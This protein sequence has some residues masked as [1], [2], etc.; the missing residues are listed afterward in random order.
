MVAFR[1][2]HLKH[3]NEKEKHKQMLIRKKRTAAAR[4]GRSRVIL[5]VV[6]VKVTGLMG[7]KQLGQTEAAV[8]HSVSFIILRSNFGSPIQTTLSNSFI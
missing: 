8:Y 6:R 2:R 3:L 1:N 5:A 4:I 7:L